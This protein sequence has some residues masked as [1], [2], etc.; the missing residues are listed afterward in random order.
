MRIIK[1]ALENISYMLDED[2]NK[3]WSTTRFGTVFF[4]FPAVTYVFIVDSLEKGLQWENMICYGLLISAP[5][6]IVKVLN[7]KYKS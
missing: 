2:D 4:M 3:R 1:K 7:A 6:T 5:R